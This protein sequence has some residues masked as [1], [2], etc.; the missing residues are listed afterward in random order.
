MLRLFKMIVLFFTSLVMLIPQASPSNGQDNP[1][2]R[3]NGGDP[4]I[5]NDNGQFYYTYT[6]GNGIVIRHIT[7]FCNT[8]EIER[9]TVYTAGRNDIVGD[10]WAPEIH[11]INS[12]WYIIAS[13]LFDKNKVEKGAM[14]LASGYNDNNDW[15]RYGFVLESV[16]DDIFGDYEFKGRL[17]PAGLN[18]IDGTFMQLNGKLYFIFSGYVDCAYQC[19]YITE[20]D[21]PYT[22]K[23]C[24]AVQK[25]SSPIYSWERK[26][27]RVNEGPAVLQHGGGTWIAYSA[28]GFTSG[29]YCLGL[30]SF[31][32][33]NPLKKWNW[34]KSPIP[35]FAKNPVENIYNTGHCSFVYVDDG[36]YMVYHASKTPSLNDSPRATHIQKINFIGGVPIF[37]KPSGTFN[38]PV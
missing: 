5:A 20:M 30:L 16:T 21:N 3:Y 9:K 8:E 17:A 32:G 10:I 7:S 37:E 13:A 38:F 6:T 29:N 25:L 23:P 35:V 14:P 33:G 24:S 19:I 27:W 18:N 1:I 12:K 26:G 15:Y 2:D 31:S 28:S 11:Q 4:Y 22:V 36:V 34:C